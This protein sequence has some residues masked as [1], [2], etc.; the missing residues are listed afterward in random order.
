[1][2]N[3]T[4]NRF[5]IDR[6]R[7]DR[8]CNRILA[9]ATYFII[10]VFLL[11]SLCLSLGLITWPT[12]NDVQF[13]PYQIF[14]TESSGSEQNRI[15]ETKLQKVRDSRNLYAQEGIWRASSILAVVGIL[16]LVVTIP[17]LIL[18]WQ[19]LKATKKTLDETKSATEAAIRTATAAENA[20]RPFLFS[21]IDPSP[22]GLEAVARKNAVPC[23]NVSVENLG[24]SPA[25]N[26][27][28]F[29]QY[30]TFNG[31]FINERTILKSLNSPSGR[32]I[33]SLAASERAS[34]IMLPIE[35]IFK[36]SLS[37]DTSEG[38]GHPGSTGMIVVL[39]L[40]YRDLIRETIEKKVLVDAYLI[41]SVSGSEV[42]I[43]RASGAN[44]SILKS[45]D[46]EVREEFFA[47][48]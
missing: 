9:A 42:T 45:F 34:L 18:I 5:L 13:N 3:P 35:T 37:G 8:R 47:D 26:I 39:S 7:A 30:G 16:Q 44:E 28:T 4:L 21:R 25:G 10:A 6:L 48:N 11:I 24:K 20:E 29:I 36:I 38:L 32:N 14:G 41:N 43:V 19:T 40:I 15:N 17:T 33:S 46:R 27:S 23:I 22:S 12:A 31:P 1:M 2:K